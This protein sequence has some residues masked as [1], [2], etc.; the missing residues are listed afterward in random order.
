[1]VDENRTWANDALR[2]ILVLNGMDAIATLLWIHLG[3]ATEA[4]PLLTALAHQ[5]PVAFVATK[6]ALVSLGVLLLVRHRARRLARVA[7][8]TG[9]AVYT[10]VC[11]YH[12][13]FAVLNA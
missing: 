13:S 6:L 10:L 5:Q 4:N 12:V 3:L 1:V 11:A 8:A 9:C 2:G 7:A